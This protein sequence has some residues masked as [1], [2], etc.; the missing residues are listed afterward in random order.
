MTARLSPG[1]PEGDHGLE[2]ITGRLVRQPEQVQV[3]IV[4]LD[5]IKL[6]T[7]VDS[8][9]VSPTVRIRA[10]EPFNAASDEAERLRSML[11]AAYEERTGQGELPFDMR[12]V[13][14]EFP[15]GAR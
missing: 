15:G 4:L 2:R 14:A 5:T 1:L 3:A 11:R 6:T 13:L 10:I 9:D 8:G 12:A 7:N